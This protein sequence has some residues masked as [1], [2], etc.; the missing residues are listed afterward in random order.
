MGKIYILKQILQGNVLFTGKI[1]TAGKKFSRRPVA[2]Q[3]SSLLPFKGFSPKMKYKPFFSIFSNMGRIGARF[4]KRLGAFFTTVNIDFFNIDVCVNAFQCQS[5]S[6]NSSMSMSV[7]MMLS[8]LQADGC[9]LAI[10]W[11]HASVTWLTHTNPTQA[12]K[13]WRHLVDIFRVLSFRGGLLAPKLG[14]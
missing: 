12:L 6:Q 9:R 2:W 10:C 4:D 1:Y 11:A 13:V 3:I 14:P 8:A 5:A 7:P